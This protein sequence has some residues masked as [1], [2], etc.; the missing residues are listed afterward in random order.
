MCEALVNVKYKVHL[1]HLSNMLA[2]M[3]RLA[4]SA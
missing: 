2:G 4:S 3:A 1:V